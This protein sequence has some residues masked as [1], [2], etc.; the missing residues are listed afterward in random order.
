MLEKQKRNR[1]NVLKHTLKVKLARNVGRIIQVV[2]AW[3]FQI[4][5]CSLQQRETD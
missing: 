2:D 5:N 3:Q 4:K 1:K